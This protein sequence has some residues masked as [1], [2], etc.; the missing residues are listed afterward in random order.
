MSLTEN[1][2]HEAAQHV[3]AVLKYGSYGRFILVQNI[4]FVTLTKLNSAKSTH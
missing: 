4:L 1:T 2:Q 3:Q